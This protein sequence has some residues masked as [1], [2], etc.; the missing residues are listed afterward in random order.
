[1]PHECGNEKCIHIFYSETCWNV[2]TGMIDKNWKIL[3]NVI[4]ADVKVMGLALVL[5]VL[6]LRVVLP[7][8]YLVVIHSFGY[9]VLFYETSFAAGMA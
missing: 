4:V 1:M 2:A 5:A 7:E 8:N 3:L 6:N 9:S